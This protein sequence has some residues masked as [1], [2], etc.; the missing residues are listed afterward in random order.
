MLA[1]CCQ[2][3]LQPLKQAGVAFVAEESGADCCGS[4]K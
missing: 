2:D 3:A 1:K 4:K